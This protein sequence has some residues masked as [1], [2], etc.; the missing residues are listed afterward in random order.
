MK[1]GDIITPYN[2]PKCNGR[3]Q[4]WYTDDGNRGAEDRVRIIYPNGRVEYCWSFLTHDKTE[5]IGGKE[6][7]RGCTSRRSQ[8]AACLAA[9][10]Y[11]RDRSEPPI[12][13]FLG[14]L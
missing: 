6:W 10:E 7:E 9:A 12:T 13:Y 8:E 11:G 4:L 14:Y 3:P 1:P 2:L 5:W